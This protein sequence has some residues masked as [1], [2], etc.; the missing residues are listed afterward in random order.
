MTKK[1]SQKKRARLMRYINGLRF[2]FT[3]DNEALGGEFHSY[4]LT[5]KNPLV[6]PASFKPLGNWL[7]DTPMRWH[8]TVACDISEEDEVVYEVDI[9]DYIKGS[10]LTAA[11]NE[12]MEDGAVDHDLVLN[13][14][15]CFEC[16]GFKKCQ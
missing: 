16:R 11:V 3:V 8:A 6:D 12:V 10:D 1:I 13:Y 4:S 7:F 2:N 15:I 14:K 9:Q 5:H